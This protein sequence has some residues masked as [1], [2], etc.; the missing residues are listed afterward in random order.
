MRP[1]RQRSSKYIGVTKRPYFS[2][3]SGSGFRYEVRI[4]SGDTQYMIGRFPTEKQAALA[5]NIAWVI[6]NDGE[7]Y[8]IQN[9]VNERIFSTPEKYKEFEQEITTKVRKLI[10]ED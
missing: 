1:T 10:K 8:F 7:S 2:V 5:Y 9:K 4:K 3:V 6:I